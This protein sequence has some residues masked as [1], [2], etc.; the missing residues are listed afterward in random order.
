MQNTERNSQNKFL[1]S[2]EKCHCSNKS[3]MRVSEDISLSFWNGI[4][5]FFAFLFTNFTAEFLLRLTHSYINQ[6]PV[7][8]GKVY[9]YHNIRQ[10]VIVPNGQNS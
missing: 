6:V 2:Q 8:I 1:R 4:L 3:V 5:R 9:F 7:F 10:V